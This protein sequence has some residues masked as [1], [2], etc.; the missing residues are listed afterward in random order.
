MDRIQSLRAS[1]RSCLALHL[2]EESPI[3]RVIEFRRRVGEEFDRLVCESV[4]PLPSDLASQI[5]RGE[6]GETTGA[7]VG[8][9]PPPR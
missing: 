5:E 2:E 3:E 8:A 1:F 4:S 7:G 6:S 9:M